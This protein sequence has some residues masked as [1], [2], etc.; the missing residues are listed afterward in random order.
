MSKCNV[1]ER[2]RKNSHNV[3]MHPL[4]STPKWPPKNGR[5]REMEWRHVKLRACSIS[6][7][8]MYGNV[9]LL[10]CY[11]VGLCS[12]TEYF[13]SLD[14]SDA[15]PGTSPDKPLRHVAAAVKVLKPG[16]ICTIRGG[17]YNESVVIAALKGTLEKP[18][19]FRAYPG[20]HVVFDGTAQ[21]PEDWSLYKGFIYTTTIQQPVWQLFVD[22]QMQARVNEIE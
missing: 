3:S 4:V 8:A 22:D 15:N 12:S 17:Q 13:V 21:I 2:I 1:L 9:I 6:N 19:T 7:I 14:G 10:C 11:L 16:D 20:E 5:A 18:I